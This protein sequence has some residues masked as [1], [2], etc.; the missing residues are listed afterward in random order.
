MGFKKIVWIGGAITLGLLLMGGGLWSYLATAT[1]QVVEAAQ[2][3]VPIDFEI[4]RARG[5]VRDLVPEIRKNMQI[6]AREEVEVERLG[7]QLAEAERNLAGDKQAILQLKGDVEEAKPR[8]VYAGKEY[9]QAEVRNDLATK[10]ARYRTAEANYQSLCAIK[11][12]RMQSLD[13]ARKK[14]EGMLAVKRQLEV[15]VEQLEARLRMLEVA[16]TTSKVQFDESRLGKAKEVV[17]QIRTRLAVAEK[18]LNSETACAGEIELEEQPS[19]DIV[20]E[21]AE[22]FGDQNVSLASMPENP[23]D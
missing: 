11:D 19:G 2:D 21:V 8:Y 9:S 1:R 23:N 15:D 22:Y 6:I 12:A 3:A 7:G 18:V 10:F 5:M 16:Q 14:L 20:K 13:A 4:E 17:E